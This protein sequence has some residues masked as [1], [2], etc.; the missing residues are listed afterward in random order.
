MDSLGVTWGESSHWCV[1]FFRPN[2]SMRSMRFQFATS[3]LRGLL[4]QFSVAFWFREIGMRL[5]SG[6]RVGWFKYVIPFK[7]RIIK[8][9]GSC[10]YMF[11]Q[12]CLSASHGTTEQILKLKNQ[13][14]LQFGICSKMEVFR[15]LL[16]RQDVFSKYLTLAR[17]PKYWMVTQL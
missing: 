13:R 8:I 6:N 11:I 7:A 2:G 16:V 4:P 12:R 5:F 9:G 14:L 10:S 3:S 1:A 17:K 15:K